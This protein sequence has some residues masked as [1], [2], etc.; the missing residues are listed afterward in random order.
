MKHNRILLV[1]SLLALLSAQDAN[2]QT[3]MRRAAGVATVSGIVTD[4]A[5]Q[6]PLE[7]VQVSSGGFETLTD[8]QGHYRL[9]VASTLGVLTL[10][11]SQYVTREVSLRGDSTVDVKMYSE[12][13]RGQLSPTAF[14]TAVT[15]VSLDEVLATRAAGSVRSVSRGAQAAM[16]SNLFIRGINSLNAST[17]PLIVVDG[18]I[19]DEPSE[20]S[21]LFSGYYENPL[22]D[23]DVNDIEDVTILKDA[24][25][26]Y[27]AKGAGGAIVITT[28]R[29][30][31]SITRIDADV[32]YGFNFRPKTY[33][34]M[35]A[36]DFRS[37]LSE[38][39]KGTTLGTQMATAFKGIL[40]NNPA[41]TD[42]NT[43]HNQTCWADEVYRTGNTQ[44]YGVSV[45]G[46]DD[47][48]RYA[49]SIGYTS[50]DATEKSVDFS[51][52]NARINADIRLL[53]NL[54]LGT[55]VYYTYTTRSLQ[56]DGVDEYTSPTHVANIKAP[57]LVPYSYTD[58]GSQL[59]S[60][61]N[62]V[63]DLGVS[64]PVAILANAKNSS[65][66]YRFGL[67]I[68]PEWRINRSLSLSG[69]F[70]YTFASSKD[71]Y[72]SPMLGVTQ[73]K[74]DGNTW[75]NTVKD[76][77]IT[78]NNLYGDI[79]LSYKHDW[80]LHH[81][82][83]SLTYR[84]MHASYKGTYADGHNT[85]NEKVTNL[86]N[87]LSWRELGGINTDWG[88]M[89][90]T[91]RAAYTYDGRYTL[92]GAVSEEASSRF[93]RDA[94][95]GLRMLGGTWATFPSVG[96]EWHAEREAFMRGV[97]SIDRLKIHAS[98]GLTGND[99][100]DAMAR[101]ATLTGVNYLTNS[102]GLVIGQL[103]N[104][105]LRWETTAKFNAGF[106]VA[107]LNDR[108]GASF[109][110][111]RHTTSN[112]L[113]Y[114]QPAVETGQQSYLCNGGKL[115]NE[116]FEAT[117]WVRPLVL[118]NF[119]WMLSASASHYKNQVTQLP[120]GDYTTTILGGE[121][122]TSV[123]NPVALFYGYKTNGIYQTTA[124]AS[125]DGLKVQNADASYSSFAA[126]DVRFVDTNADG[127]ISDADKQIIGDPNPDIT[128]SIFNRFTWKKL[129]LE[130]LCTY[131]LGGDVYNYQRQQL[132]KLS[133]FHN[134]TTAALGRWKAEGQAA[135]MPRATYGDPMGNAR[136]SDR[137]IEDG[138]FFKLKNV[139]LSYDFDINTTY[140]HGLTVWAAASDLL[141]LTKYLGSDPEVSMS[142]GALYQGIDNGYLA[143]GRS[144]YMG[145][146]IKL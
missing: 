129:S 91:A 118:K 50:N 52:L 3:K 24:T 49:I 68:A 86:N 41:S 106:D 96:A 10:K 88:S 62:D 133:A 70:S 8:A 104:S 11:T 121:V 103:A 51:R 87:S 17:Q 130:V 21:S 6:K 116:G 82:D 113:T 141:T 66:H 47:V 46:S 20:S 34:M 112:L 120:D 35:G 26:I 64:N 102:T 1:A 111:F 78:R 75:E 117:V 63:D 28:K 146:K 77:S 60:S 9:D 92:W 145:V 45:D 25:S 27:G 93:G 142:S 59:T 65:K 94:D 57:F 83:A 128:G 143:A 110:Y 13:F 71:H 4:A 135:T 144:F 61:L 56:D 99:G 79:A 95:G 85:G 107:L 36:N 131:S 72:F 76:Q 43:Y 73:K 14:S 37:Y 124:E 2:A 119:S 137:W 84:V 139:K 40:G 90:L 125:A 12:H 134:Q 122:L 38:V 54:S 18:T 44:H 55:Q 39:M 109:D 136:F 98:Y 126:G 58:D 140:I 15:E 31:S 81:L 80:Q 53:R 16:G 123:G 108:L 97:R 5:T 22:A 127:I 32:S 101:H 114:K 33:D 115:R 89:S 48:A 100:I 19:W 30:H 132:E 67:S 42:Y 74:V 138:S 105:K 7:G 69:R 23:I 29:S